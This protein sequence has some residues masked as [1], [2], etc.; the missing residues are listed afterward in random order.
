MTLQVADH[1][2][3][4]LLERKG[5]RVALLITKGF[6]DLL[7]IGNQARPHIFDLT[8]KK[9]QTLYSTVV[10]IDERV[11]IESFSENPEPRP[12]DIR[13]D[14]DLVQGVAGEPVRIIKRPNLK[15]IRRD[16][17][18]LW[19]QGYR[20]LALALM[21]SHTYPEHDLSIMQTA[22]EMGFKVAT[23][24]QLHAMI[25]IIPHTQSATSD[26]Y[27]SPITTRYIDSFRRSFKGELRE[28]SKNRLLI[29]Q[30]DGVL[31]QVT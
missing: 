6:R 3:S 14:P 30:S 13:S 31:H 15:V 21:H 12:I 5:E 24:S 20:T 8:V 9:L 25:K 7:A 1:A 19:D 17:Q 18:D 22:E 2:C 16:L 10:E 26:A 4:A 28:E 27:L 11:T 29:S 23:S